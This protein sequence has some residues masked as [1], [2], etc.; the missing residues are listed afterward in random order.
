MKSL[1]IGALPLSPIY[2]NP[3]FRRNAIS[4]SFSGGTGIVEHG[5]SQHQDGT[6]MKLMEDDKGLK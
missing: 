2:S 3:N 1:T 6:Q 5:V 4:C